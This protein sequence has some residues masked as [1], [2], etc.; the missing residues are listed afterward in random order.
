MVDACSDLA[1]VLRDVQERDLLI[2]TLLITHYHGDHTFALGDWLKEL[3]NLSIGIHQ[4]SLPALVSAGIDTKQVFPLTE[5]AVVKVGEETLRVMAAPGHTSD[6]LC[7]WDDRG[8]NLFTGDVLF[9]GNI[10]CSDYRRG[11]NRNIFFQTIVKLLKALPTSTQLYPGHLS[12]HYQTL[13]PYPLAGEKTQNP[14]VANA[15]TGKRGNFDRALKYFSLEFETAEVLMLDASALEDVCRLEA[16]IWIPELQAPRTV[17][18]ERLLHGHKLLTIK[19]EGEFIG[20]VG[21]CYSPFAREDGPDGFPHNFRDFSNCTSC[22]SE[23]AQSAFIYNVGV[24]PNLRRQGMGSLLLQ[25]AFEK[26]RKAGISQV[27]LDSRM[28]SYNGSAQHAQEK[29]LRRQA[30]HEA[31]DG[32]FR[33]GRLP[34]P[35][36]LSSDSTVSFYMKN[37][38]SPWIIRRDFIPDEPSGN[39]RVICY[40]NL[41]QDPP[42]FSAPG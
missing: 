10:G 6:S 25:E 15:L 20:M 26:I 4:A 1:V 14:Y 36:V 21:W 39:M 19:E 35:A 31:V 24:R 22:C 37:G 33:T 3:P 11:G 30:F 32:Y 34:E 40:L 12:E 8:R 41:D 17:I 2:E 18:Q 7:F 29:V 27:F 42:L 38:F 9:G 16:E 28:A 13:P 23:T 5:G